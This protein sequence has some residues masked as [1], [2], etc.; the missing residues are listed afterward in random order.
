MAGKESCSKQYFCCFT[1]QSIAAALFQGHRG[2]FCEM[3]S[4]HSSPCQNGGTCIAEANIYRCRCL[5][6]YYG[7]NCQMIG[8]ICQSNPCL[9]HGVCHEQHLGFFCRCSPEWTGKNCEIS[10]YCTKHSCASK[11]KDGVCQVRRAVMCFS[12]AVLVIS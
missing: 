9:N 5:P 12:F 11:A 3:S 10:S 8:I 2:E 4:C 7:H 6:N 1:C